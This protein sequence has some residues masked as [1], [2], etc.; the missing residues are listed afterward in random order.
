MDKLWMGYCFG[1][2]LNQLIDG[3]KAINNGMFTI[4]Q[5]VYRISQPQYDM[6]MG[7]NLS[8]HHILGNNQI[9]IH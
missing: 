8:I 4:Y 2:V 5:L 7:Q 1:H 9:T 3:W 6:G